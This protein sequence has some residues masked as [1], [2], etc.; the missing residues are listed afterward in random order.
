MSALGQSDLPPKSGHWAE[1]MTG[2]PDQ[3]RAKS[4]LDSVQAALPA[5]ALAVASMIG[6]GI[7]KA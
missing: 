5:G 7:E 4:S 1:Q 3:P 2:S 6:T